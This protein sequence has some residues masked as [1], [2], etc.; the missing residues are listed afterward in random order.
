MLNKFLFQA[1]QSSLDLSGHKQLIYIPLLSS[2]AAYSILNQYFNGHVLK[3]KSSVSKLRKDYR[4]VLSN[5][6]S[7]TSIRDAF[8]DDLVVAEVN[9]SSMTQLVIPKPSPGT[10][11]QGNKLHH[12]KGEG[13]YVGQLV[14]EKSEDF[15][16]ESNLTLDFIQPMN[17][18]KNVPL[19]SQNRISE[20]RPSEGSIDTLP[21]KKG[22]R[23]EVSSVDVKILKQAHVADLPC[24]YFPV[25]NSAYYLVYFHSNAEDI[26]TLRE[27]C[28]HLAEHSRCNVLV[29][30]YPGYSLY[31]GR[32]PSAKAI[33]DDADLLMQFLTSTCRIDPSKIIIVGRSLGSGPAVH[34]ASK[35]RYAL[36]TLVAPFLCI[37]QLAKDKLSILSA[38]VDSHFDNAMKIQNN[39]TPLLLLHG[40]Q[41]KLIE[42]RHSEELYKLARSKAKIIVFES[43]THNEFNF[44]SCVVQPM[45]DYLKTLTMNTYIMPSRTEHRSRYK[46]N[47]DPPNMRIA[48]LFKSCLF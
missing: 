32:E 34:V 5:S 35:Q 11:Q 8:E 2:E 13:Q 28:S 30:E 27:L 17:S 26:L 29:P 37:K 24:M 38:F 9:K 10:K 33:C 21:D 3:A 41:D 14:K 6:K 43:M 22:H 7:N 46:G 20:L 18:T 44:H 48:D 25:E 19:D 39:L 12:L 36:L 45:M 4:F 15:L 23:R 1:P 40:K 42:V 31:S 47:K 16:F